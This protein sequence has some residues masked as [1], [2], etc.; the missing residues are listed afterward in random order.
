VVDAHAAA[1]LGLIDRLRTMIE[2]DPKLVH[3]RGGDG[4]TPLHFASTVEVAAYLIEHG[5]DIDARDVDHESTPAQYM[6]DHR[7]DLA[8]YLVERGCRTDLLLAAAVGDVKRVRAH[9][10]ADPGCLNIRANAEWFPMADPRAGGIIYFWTIGS[11]ASAYQ[12]AAK[13]GHNDVLALLIERSPANARLVASCWL[14]DEA[15][16][17][18]L[19]AAHP[20]LAAKLTEVERNEVARAARENQANVVRLML[21][22]GLPVTAR[23]QHRGTPLHWGAWHG[24]IAMVRE[25]LRYGPPL[26]DVANDYHATPLGWATHG[27]E[28][29]WHRGIGDYPAVVEALL[30]AGAKRPNSPAGTEPV[31]DV[32]RRHCINNDNV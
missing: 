3:A 25:I 6:L 22:S 21:E 15:G 7:P 26:D 11:D 29:G 18:G 30:A 31:K 17:Q 28:N 9:L 20:G 8:R 27:S 2:S 13:F 4:Q 5:A 1:R 23:G 12:A 19:L 16:V 10:E 14:G 32:L 24:N